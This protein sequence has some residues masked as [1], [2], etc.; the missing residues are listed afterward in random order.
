MNKR[1]AIVRVESNCPYDVDGTEDY[2][3]L[4]TGKYLRDCG[5][6]KFGQEKIIVGDTKEQLV[7][8]VAQVFFKRKLKSY[9][10]LFDIVPNNED[11]KQVYKYCLETAKEIVEF[12][13]VEDERKI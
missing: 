13:G 11:A 2:C 8:K 12:L 9:K 7:A 10:K 5:Y 1:Y 6:C 4:N 3:Y